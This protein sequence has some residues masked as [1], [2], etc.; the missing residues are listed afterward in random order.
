MSEFDDIIHLTRPIS[1]N[2][3]P[4]QLIN[5][6][7]QFGAFKALSGHAEALSE[8]AR[9][10]DSWKEITQEKTDILNQRISEAKAHIDEN[11]EVKVI[12][13]VPDEKKDGGSYQ[14]Y[15][16][17]LRIIDDTLNILT[18]TNGM[19]IPFSQIYNFELT[20]NG[21]DKT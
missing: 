11:P 7:A 12:Y 19:Q 3:P 6:A 13:F 8:E 18:F 9:I 4:M 5:R 15:I 14:T 20:K 1:K 10:T 17:K 16:G 2:H 21:S